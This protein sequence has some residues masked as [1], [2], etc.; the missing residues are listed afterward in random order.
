MNRTVAS[1]LACG[2]VIAVLFVA[3][4]TSGEVPLAE[5]YPTITWDL[6]RGTVNTI[7]VGGLAVE[8]RESDA[9]TGRQLRIPDFVS[10]IVQVLLAASGVALLIV[11]WGRRP[12]LRWRRPRSAEDFEVLADL[13][14]VMAADSGAQRALLEI[15]EPRNAIVACWLRLEDL[16]ASAGHDRH[17]ADTSEEFTARIL[18]R[19]AVDAAAVDHLASLY[20]E[21]R[22]SSHQ[23]GEPQREAA[24]RAL[25]AVHEGLPS[26]DIPAAEPGSVPTS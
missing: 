25:G 24:I 8:G 16:I 12:R 1:I 19:F 11:L 4:S 15:G 3:V 13:A 9:S 26:V 14:S 2:A 7:P 17:P 18:S 23:M 10:A 21:A 20:R 6:D 22:F 5:S